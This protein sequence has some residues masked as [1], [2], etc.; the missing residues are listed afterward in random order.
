MSGARRRRQH[1]LS[2]VELML[3]LAL[4]LF[5]VAVATALLVNRLR[6]HRALLVESRLMQDLRSTA[7]LVGRDLRRAGHW[8]DATAALWQA[9]SAVVANPYTELTPAS[10]S[11]T[12]VSFR[13]SRDTVENHAVDSHEEF[14]FR[15]RQGA[16]EMLIGGGSWQ[17]LTDKGTMQVLSFDISPQVREISLAGL[18]AKPCPSGLGDCPPKQQLRSVGIAITGRSAIDHQVVRSASSEVRLR[19]DVVS[20]RCPA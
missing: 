2:L 3:G 10:G 6:E 9:G 4:G 14:G 12:A 7:A 15:L 20:G 1:G 8:G 17:A 19:N 5:I 13:F 18:C 11:T 16:I